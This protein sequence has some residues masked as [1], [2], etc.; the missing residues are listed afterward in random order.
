[1]E[2]TTESWKLASRLERFLWFQEKKQFTDQCEEHGTYG[3]WGHPK[4]EER[5]YSAA[6]EKPAL[7][8]DA[9]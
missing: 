7:E 8:P 4:V 9:E 2:G 5:D 1:M 3:P 6:R